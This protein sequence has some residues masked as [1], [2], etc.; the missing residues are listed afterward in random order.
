MVLIKTSPYTNSS[1]P[2]FIQAWTTT[3]VATDLLLVGP[4]GSNAMQVGYACRR[5]TVQ[6]AGT[7]VITDVF[8]NV[9]TLTC[10]SGES[11]D[12]EGVSLSSESTAQGVKVLW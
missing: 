11:L 2:Y 5:I 3:P 1:S 12:I 4:G 9:R 10:A 8:G 7:L 6:T